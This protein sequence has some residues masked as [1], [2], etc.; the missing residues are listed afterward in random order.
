MI[1]RRRFSEDIADSVLDKVF[2]LGLKPGDRLPTHIQ[3]SEI[4]GV[5]LPSLREGLSLLSISGVINITHG[6]GTTLANPVP[7]DYFK[8]LKP[9]SRINRTRVEDLSDFCSIFIPDLAA[10]CLERPESSINLLSSLVQCEITEGKSRFFKFHKDFHS[11]LAE[12]ITNPL[13]KS[14]FLIA[15]NLFYTHPSVST[16]SVPTLLFYLKSHKNLIKTLQSGVIKDVEEALKDCYRFQVSMEEHVSIFYESFGKGSLGG[17][18]YS[19]AKRFTNLLKGEENIDIHLEITGGGIEN[20]SLTEE[21]KTILAFT[22]ADIAESAYRGAGMFEKAHPNLRIVCGVRPLDLWIVTSEGTDISSLHDLKGRRIAMGAEGGDSG[23][24]ARSIFQNLGFETGDYR[25]Y[26]LSLSN[27]LQGLS[28]NEI[29]VVFFLAHEIPSAVK[30]LSDSEDLVFLPI[31]PEIIRFLEKQNSFWKESVCS[32]PLHHEGE[33]STIS[34][35]TVLITA[36][37]VP[38]SLICR[39]ATILKKKSDY[40][41]QISFS[42]ASNNISVPFHPGVLECLKISP[43]S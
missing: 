14:A 17:S 23:V 12:S 29:D 33:I 43:A 13:K 39:I 3:L 4:L 25:P 16:I 6:A 27:A 41:D 10:S 1:K 24:V 2:E 20:I 15:L 11:F 22:Q 36:S 5:S 42:F 19:M 30:D 34:V 7:D 35:S 37:S 32:L 26:Y 8:M 21:C 31:P 40:R 18:F 9:I 38:D 28:S